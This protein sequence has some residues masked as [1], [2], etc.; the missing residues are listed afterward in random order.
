MEYDRVM[1]WLFSLVRKFS[2]SLASLGK[3][4]MIW[5]SVTT[6]IV[7]LLGFQVYDEGCHRASLEAFSDLWRK[8]L[9]VEN[10]FIFMWAHEKFK[11]ET[12]T[13]KTQRMKSMD[14]QVVVR[15]IRTYPITT[16][17]DSY[18]L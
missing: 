6:S 2:E 7:A 14:G 10:G 18:V 4:P 5:S 8:E 13:R 1:P 11:N 16:D 12:K 9:S 3:V 15:N 17:F